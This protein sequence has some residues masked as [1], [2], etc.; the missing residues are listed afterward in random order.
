M[1]TKQFL[2]I[3]LCLL[4]MGQVF[5]TNERMNLTERTKSWLQRSP[6]AQASGQGGGRAGDGPTTDPTVGTPIGS[7]LPIII[8]LMGVYGLATVKRNK[9]KFLGEEQ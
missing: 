6:T 2:T 9:I 5:A 8:L 1:K 7:A 4:S 3:I